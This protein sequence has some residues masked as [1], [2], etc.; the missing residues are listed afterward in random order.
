MEFD[1]RQRVLRALRHN[2][3]SEYIVTP[4]NFSWEFAAKG[5]SSIETI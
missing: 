2:F 1:I 3:G 4:S 5:I